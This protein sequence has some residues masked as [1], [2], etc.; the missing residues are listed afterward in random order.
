MEILAGTAGVVE[1][2]VLWIAS[3]YLGLREDQLLRKKNPLYE[4]QAETTVAA[5]EPS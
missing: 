2:R 4:T 5:T 1:T 3:Q